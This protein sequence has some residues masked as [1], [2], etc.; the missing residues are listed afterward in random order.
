MTAILRTPRLLLRELDIA[1][2]DFVAAMLGDP[3]VMRHYPKVLT[4]EESEAWMRRQFLRYARDGHGLWLVVNRHTGV[5]VGQVGPLIQIVDD[6]PE[7]EIGWLIHRPYWRLGYATEAAAGVL[8]YV[9]TQLGKPR[10]IALIRPVNEPSQGVAR[11]L[12]MT[13][14]GMTMHYDYEH[15]VFA[16]DRPDT[17]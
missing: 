17:A 10:A 12:G 6:K 8:D 14:R 2:L 9:F 5:P 15:I 13:P 4:R 16:K 1:D 11:K 7:T 3:E